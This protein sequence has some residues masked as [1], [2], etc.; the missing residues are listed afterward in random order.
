METPNSTIAG[1]Q[2]SN[3]CWKRVSHAGIIVFL[4]SALFSVLLWDLHKVHE[5]SIIIHDDHT[6]HWIQMRPT[7]LTKWFTP[8]DI[9]MLNV[10]SPDTDLYQYRKKNCSKLIPP[11]ASVPLHLTCGIGS[12]IGGKVCLPPLNTRSFFTAQ[13]RHPLLGNASNQLLRSSL[14]EFAVRNKPVVFV[15][16]GISK[17]NTDALLC[18]I[19]RTDLV[20][21]EGSNGPIDAN[22]TIR[23]KASKL[24]LDV[25]YMK[26]TNMYDNGENE[27]AEARRIRRARRKALSN[28]TDPASE[29]NVTKVALS[30]TLPAI[31]S[32]VR[33]IIE[34]HGN[35]IVLVVNV[36]VW[37]NS[38]EL[39][40]T[41]LPDLLAWMNDLS[42]VHN[43]TVYFRE[44]AAQHW[45]H[46]SSGYFDK[47][48]AEA[49]WDNGTCTPVGDATPG[50]FFIFR[51]IFLLC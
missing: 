15:G 34:S 32:R 19:M 45:N 35:G 49:R 18:E 36:G 7:D 8:V 5:M 29:R 26:L 30:M 24:K 50:I 38:R 37:Y 9:C 31:Q 4:F 44:T 17:Q 14:R 28:T 3:K 6:S 27:V 46:T 16:D 41:E 21:L 48:Y 10:S 43:S 12:S 33:S 1:H 25:H 51:S 47:D 39:F 42:A 13:L 23:W 40:R 22:Y 11:K 20:T 2:E